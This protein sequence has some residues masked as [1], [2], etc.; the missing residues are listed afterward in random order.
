MLNTYLY[1]HQFPFLRYCIAFCAGIIIGESTHAIDTLTIVYWVFLLTLICVFVK[2]KGF[3]GILFLIC[4]VLVGAQA[5]NSELINNLLPNH[6]SVVIKVTEF[7]KKT[8]NYLRFRAF[9]IKSMNG[10]LSAS[11]DTKI[12]LYVKGRDFESFPNVG[13]IFLLQKQ[14]DEIEKSNIKGQFDYGEY[15]HFQGID[16]QVF[17]DT[18]KL[19]KLGSEEMW[20]TRKFQDIRKYVESRFSNCLEPAEFNVAM[21][22]FLGRKVYLNAAQK[23]HYA[24]SGSM[25]LLAVSGLHTGIIYLICLKVFGFLFHFIRAKWPVLLLS[26]TLVWFYCI[27]TGSS[28]SVLRASF[29]LSIISLTGMISRNQNIYNSIFLSAFV[30]LLI[31]PF[32][33]YQVGFQLS[34]MAVLGIVF[35]HKRIYKLLTFQRRATDLIWQLVCMGISA[36][37]TTGILS[38]YY[39]HQFPSYFL[40]TNLL[41]PF[42]PILIG[43]GILFLVLSLISMEHFPGMLLQF[44]FQTMNK[45]VEWVSGLPGSTIGHLYLTKLEGIVLYGILAMI[46]I[47]LFLRK[48]YAMLAACMMIFVF[49]S[50]QVLKIND[51]IKPEILV[52]SDKKRLAIDLVAREKYSTIDLNSNNSEIFD[53]QNIRGYHGAHEPVQAKYIKF[54]DHNAG[55]FW[56]GS[57]ILLSNSKIPDIILHIR[58][59]DYILTDQ[60]DQAFPEGVNIID[61]SRTSFSVINLVSFFK[62]DYFLSR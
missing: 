45:F 12:L 57:W 2:E 54:D 5:V 15:L 1:W 61:H 38:I 25:H 52:Y 62:R 16:Y 9:V 49:V 19:I 17:T 50:V 47:L 8:S 11:H 21:A 53:I 20:F 36:Q 34:Y 23:S 39:F 13:D 43:L 56:S 30:L 59:W 29:M 41:V 37:L 4:W 44:S 60:P 51:H 48:F 7:E 6:D 14:L 40:L 24:N 10:I 3:R 35:F 55:I 27:L 22:L 18:D 58:P 32:L 26:I 28:P 46:C 33:L 42:A 31:N